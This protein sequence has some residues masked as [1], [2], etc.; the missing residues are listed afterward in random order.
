MATRGHHFRLAKTE[1]CYFTTRN[2]STRL[3]KKLFVFF[4]I[5]VKRTQTQCSQEE[6]E[7]AIG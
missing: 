3:N 7:K 5:Q 2:Y 6:K 4:F 1:L